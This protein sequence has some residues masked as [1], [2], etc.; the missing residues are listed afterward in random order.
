MCHLS[1]FFSYV[2]AVAYKV[3]KHIVLVSVLFYFIKPIANMLKRLSLG[4]VIDNEG[5]L[6]IFIEQLSDGSELL[7]PRGVPYLQL[8]DGTLV[9]FHDKG[10]ELHSYRYLMIS[11]E[12]TLCKH[13]HETALSD[14]GIPDNN[15]L[16]EAI[17]LDLNGRILY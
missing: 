2:H 3:D 11:F 6:T 5:R 10:A 7:L 1:L 16:E 17:G 9:H 15:D 8:D 12:G 4:D 14:P 13:L